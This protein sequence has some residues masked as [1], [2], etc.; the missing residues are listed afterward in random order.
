MTSQSDDPSALPRRP[1]Q[2]P[3]ADTVQQQLRLLVQAVEA[4]ANATYRT[5][6]KHLSRGN[7][8]A[9]TVARAR[10]L[11]QQVSQLGGWT[12]SLLA[13]GTHVITGDGEYVVGEPQS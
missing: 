9:P 10:E 8:V 4:L 5:D 1:Q 7:N 2:A 11:A 12:D 6:N 3:P 13:V